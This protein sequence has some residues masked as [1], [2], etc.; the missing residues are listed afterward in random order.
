[1]WCWTGPAEPAGPADVDVDAED[2]PQW[3]IPLLLKCGEGYVERMK[4]WR[5][6]E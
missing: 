2:L 6:G 1:M 5:S 3:S 4:E